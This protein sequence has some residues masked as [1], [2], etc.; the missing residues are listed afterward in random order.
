MPKSDF[1]K[2]KVYQLAERLADEIWDTVMDWDR[3]ARNTNGYLRS[4]GRVPDK[5]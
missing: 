2:L 3:F 4:I 5:R 1:E